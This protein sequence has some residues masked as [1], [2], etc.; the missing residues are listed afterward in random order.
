MSTLGLAIAIAAEA[1][2][3]KTDRGGKPYILHC[4]HYED[5]HIEL[6]IRGAGHYC[7]V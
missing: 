1:F 4:F 2:K 6:N 5:I 3:E 7:A